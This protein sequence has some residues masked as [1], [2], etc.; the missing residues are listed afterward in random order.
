MDEGR[1][2]QCGTHEDLLSEEGIYRRMWNEQQK[3]GTWRLDAR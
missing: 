1:A 3:A 2:A